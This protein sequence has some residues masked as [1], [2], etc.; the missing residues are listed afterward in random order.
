LKLPYSGCYAMAL[1]HTLAEAGT[2]RA[3]GCKGPR[4]FDSD[5]LTVSSVGLEVTGE[6]PGLDQTGFE[7]AAKQAEQACPVSN[8]FVAT[9]RATSRR[10]SPELGPEELYEGRL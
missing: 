6:V 9:C 4:L 1:S 8:S 3:S 10:L 7:D 2:R 5:K